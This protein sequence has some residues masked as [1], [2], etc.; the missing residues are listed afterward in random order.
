MSD[1]TLTI[2]KPQTKWEAIEMYHKLKVDLAKLLVSE[3][4]LADQTD[5]FR[6]IWCAGCID[7]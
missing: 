4:L 6:F 3:L 2:K 5:V 1:F 7:Y